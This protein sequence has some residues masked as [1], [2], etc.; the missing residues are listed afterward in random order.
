VRITS[1]AFDVDAVGSP[2]QRNWI[3]AIFAQPSKRFNWQ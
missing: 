2:I 3:L 1:D